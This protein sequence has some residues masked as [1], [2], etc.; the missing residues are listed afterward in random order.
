[1]Q[2][3]GVDTN[4]IFVIIAAVL[5]LPPGLFIAAIMSPAR[6]R[7]VALLGGVI[8]DLIV[9][10]GIYFFVMSVHP[11][12]DGLSYFL[13]SLFACSAGVFTGALVADFVAGLGNRGPVTPVEY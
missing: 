5:A 12:I 6:S 8:G 4:L 1:V 10:A 2:E 11:S 13:G 3:E 7:V 9:A